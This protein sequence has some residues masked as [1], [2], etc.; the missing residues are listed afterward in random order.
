MYDINIINFSQDDMYNTE[1]YNRTKLN[2][3]FG[4]VKMFSSGKLN[5]YFD[6]EKFQDIDINGRLISISNSCIK[7][8]PEDEDILIEELMRKLINDN[9]KMYKNIYYIIRF[10][11]PN[12]EV[13]K[14]KDVIEN[15]NVVYSKYGSQNIFIIN[16]IN[17]E[18][19][20]NDYIE[21]YIFSDGKKQYNMDGFN[22]KT[23]LNNIID[24]INKGEKA[25]YKIL[26]DCSFEIL[27]IQR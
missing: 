6:I 26:S 10:S 2:F 12:Y 22:I 5:K 21:G 18:E 13:L 25:F 19:I 23:N 15:E 16:G 3:D 1:F 9:K 24:N 27:E 20:I 7:D 8:D 17:K 11:N 14:I 4:N